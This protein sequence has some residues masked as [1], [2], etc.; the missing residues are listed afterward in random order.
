MLGLV[1]TSYLISALI[2]YINFANL[3][4]IKSIYVYKTRVDEAMDWG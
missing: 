1:T 2:N 3:E 4:I